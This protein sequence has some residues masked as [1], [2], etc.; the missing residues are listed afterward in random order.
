MAKAVNSFIFLDFETGGLDARTHAVTEVAM[1]AVT[2]DSFK[3]LDMVST[4][5]KPYGEYQYDPLAL[6][7]TGINFQDIEGGEDV[8]VVANSMLELLKK[9]D[10]NPKNKG[11]KP[12]LVAHNSGFDK[13][14]FMQIM[15]HT[16]KLKEVEKLVYGTTDFYGNWQPEMM[17]TV[18]WVKMAW[19][20]DPD[21]PNFKLGTCIEKAGIELSDAHRAINDTIAMKDMILL[22]G[23]KLR[24]KGS[25]GNTDE[26]V[27]EGRFR[28]HFQF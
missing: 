20:N 23:N 26:L 10:L 21:I 12:I 4:L 22:F 24:S 7:H 15:F 16:G 28:D 18:H 5:I 25:A 1:V 17:D 19:G 11:S 13:G 6:K 8:K 9:A 3:V 27:D 14:F 2:G